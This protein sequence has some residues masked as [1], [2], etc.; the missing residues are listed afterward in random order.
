MTTDWET[1][2]RQRPRG[3]GPGRVV[4]SV[5]VIAL[6]LFGVLFFRS[7]E[8]RGALVVDVTESPLPTRSA[9]PALPVVPG[10]W[11]P[12]AE[13]PLSSRRDTAA[14][15]TG[16]ELIVWGGRMRDRLGAFGDGAAYEPLGDRWRLLPRAP[17]EAR[18]SASA[19]WTGAEVI[20]WGGVGDRPEG[21]D[22]TDLQ[23]GNPFNDGAA[24]SPDSDRWR[25]L[26][27]SPLSAR[28]DA[29]AA[30]VDGRMLVWGGAEYM[31]SSQLTDG[32]LYDPATD[33]WTL[34][35]EGPLQGLL[36]AD[37]D[38]AV[39]GDTVLIVTSSFR[40]LAIGVFDVGAQTW[41]PDVEQPP[42]RGDV[43]LALATLDGAALLWGESA[44]QPGSPIAV[45]YDPAERSWIPVDVPPRAPGRRD[46]LTSA[47]E[48]VV[49]WSD[50]RGLVFDAAAN[51]WA[52]MPDAPDIQDADI[53]QAWLGDRLA[54]WNSGLSAGSGE[55]AAA[56][57]PADTF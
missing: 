29:E 10:D 21:A 33:S 42:I 8:P 34:I 44:E 12:M 3:R 37:S 1:A 55:R 51:H 48:R 32:A 53:L 39:I 11:Q 15:W 38:M 56:W 50:G 36:A 13:G 14:A 43:P 16:T 25:R 30:W 20:V 57:V 9:A 17:L 5:V 28:R 40:G 4:T 54:V 35:P 23:F 2:R 31:G 46:T 45:R 7:A 18:G 26:A 19:V 27:E 6:V 52:T 47:G 24:Y 22:S 49:S 41:V